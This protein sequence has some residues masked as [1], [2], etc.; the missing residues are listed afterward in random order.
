M[1]SNRLF[2][3]QDQKHFV[4]IYTEVSLYE[5][6]GD[7]LTFKKQLGK[8]KNP[9][10]ICFSDVG[11]RV[12]VK[13]NNNI[14]E[15]YDVKSGL[16]VFKGKGP[17]E[18]G[19]KLFFVD[20]NTLLSSTEKGKIYTINIINGNVSCY[21]NTVSDQTELVKITTYK[22][23]ML[24]NK[25][26]SNATDIYLLSF[27]EHTASITPVCAA[28]TVLDLYSASFINGKLYAVSESN[29]LFVY[30]YSEENDQMKLEKR[31]S[32]FPQRNEKVFSDAVADTVLRLMHS[33]AVDFSPSVF[34]IGICATSGD[35]YILISFNF[36]IMVF[37]INEWKCERWIPTKYGIS[38][39]APTDN[40]RQI[41]FATS[42]GVKYSTFDCILR[43]VA[44]KDAITQRDS[45][46]C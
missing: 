4:N 44:P 9:D 13:N 17:R 34:P 43:G 8:L 23:L 27:R 21:E 46:V 25:K 40:N 16:K 5:K 41:W 22:Y 31:T 28:L 2:I 20:D 3:S 26:S 29:E 32:L 15:V 39:V 45:S 36:G 35:K 24:S 19:G 14:I 12:A 1:D 30:G 18:F 37:D 6:N 42:S 33:V 10:T 38:F 11:D 7:I